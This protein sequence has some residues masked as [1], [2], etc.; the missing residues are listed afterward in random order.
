MLF[1]VHE[2]WPGLGLPAHLLNEDYRPLCG[3]SVSP[4]SWRMVD[5]EPAAVP[6]ICYRCRRRRDH[7]EKPKRKRTASA[8]R[9]GA[10]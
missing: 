10:D 1:I 4:A 8:S 2:T 6:S 3:A 9:A 7:V 5:V